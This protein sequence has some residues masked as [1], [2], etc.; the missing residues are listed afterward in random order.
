MIIN[1]Y[2]KNE[3]QITFLLIQKN[4]RSIRKNNRAGWSK[5]TVLLHIKIF[6]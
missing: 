6:N 3:M 4:L 5:L 2:K 1:I